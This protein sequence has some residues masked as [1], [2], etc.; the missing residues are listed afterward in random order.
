MRGWKS[1]SSIGA[2]AVLAAAQAQMAK[3]MTE[4]EAASKGTG[5]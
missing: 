3:K 1:R 4:A 2:I 5:H